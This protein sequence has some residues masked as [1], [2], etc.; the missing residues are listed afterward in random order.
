MVKVRSIRGRPKSPDSGQNLIYTFGRYIRK[1]FRNFVPQS[2]I[3]WS[4][5][6]NDV[7]LKR[8]ALE[9]Y[10]GDFKMVKGYIIGI[11]EIKM[12]YFKSL[13][14]WVGR[15]LRYE[16]TKNIAFLMTRQ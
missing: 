14:K 2:L 15:N 5:K 11:Y 9:W 16:I 12:K 3:V 7:E 13:E 4:D 10:T 6:H 1:E 8:K